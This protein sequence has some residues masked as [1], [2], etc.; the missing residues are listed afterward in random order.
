MKKI[1]CSF[2]VMILAIG[3]FAGCGQ[4]TEGNMKDPNLTEKPVVI[5]QPIEGPIELTDPVVVP[6]SKP[7]KALG[8]GLNSNDVKL[9]DYLAN[10]AKKKN[11]NLFMSTMSVDM[12]LGML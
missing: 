10:Q 9:I 3:M 2:L 12:A 1:L 8:F 7:E 4:K 6:L 5:D 11:E